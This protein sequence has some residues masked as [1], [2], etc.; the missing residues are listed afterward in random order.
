ML[1]S[2]T[3]AAILF[4]LNSVSGF[5]CVLNAPV[6]VGRVFLG[7][8]VS[9]RADEA[10]ADPRNLDGCAWSRLCVC[11][12]EGMACKQPVWTYILTATSR[13]II[14]GLRSHDTQCLVGVDVAKQGSIWQC[15]IWLEARRISW[16][17]AEDSRCH[18][19]S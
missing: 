14:S 4:L 16:S 10:V 5:A 3:R 19:H 12:L 13:I 1:F 15:Q 7:I 17:I 8:H 9:L 2:V 6:E 18:H 11:V